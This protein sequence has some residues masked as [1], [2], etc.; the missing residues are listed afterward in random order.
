LRRWGSFLSLNSEER[1]AANNFAWS[2]MIFFEAKK[3]RVR[4]LRMNRG[5][6]RDNH[7]RGCVRM[8]CQP[9]LLRR[10]TYENSFIECLGP[11]HDPI[12]A[13]NAGIR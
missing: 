1:A 13:N 6:L 7:M 5:Q 11:C 8:K 3:A 12:P 9:H 10:F 2:M 4:V